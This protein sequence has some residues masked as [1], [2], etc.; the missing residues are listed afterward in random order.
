MKN[1]LKELRLSKNLKQIDVA[2]AV[3]ISQSNYSR[4][5]TG[6]L[7]PDLKTL[8]QLATFFDVSIDYIVGKDP[9][10][11]ILISK[12]DFQKLRELNEIIKKID[13]SVSSRSNETSIQI[14]NNNTI[15]DSF[16]KK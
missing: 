16:N 9:S 3:F 7:E 11:L 6:E 5:E 10:D 2:K 1:K 15:H 12:E 8:K 4:Y 14:G 13:K